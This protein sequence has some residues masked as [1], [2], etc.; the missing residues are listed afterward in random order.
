VA[1]ATNGYTVPF[2][3]LLSLAS[4][5]LVLNFSIKRP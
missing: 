3:I 2:I 4:F 1:A 5:A